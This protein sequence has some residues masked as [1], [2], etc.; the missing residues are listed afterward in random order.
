[1]TNKKH[2]LYQDKYH[3]IIDNKTLKHSSVI[4]RP[5]VRVIIHDKLQNK[6]LLLQD[7]WS[8]S[9]YGF[10][11]PEDVLYN[12]VQNNFSKTYD[13]ILRDALEMAENICKVNG[14][15]PIN[16]KLFLQDFKVRINCTYHYFLVTDFKEMQV[17]KFDKGKWIFMKDIL[18]L[19][20]NKA[21]YDEDVVGVLV[22]YFLQED[23]VK[24]N[25]K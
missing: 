7:D 10:F 14:I 18:G 20:K 3:I 11:L 2:I 4:M 15:I 22:T 21:F 6:I 16:L 1:M 12:D 25:N 13:E 23:E 8:E 19:I 24:Y 17:E 9:N 5:K